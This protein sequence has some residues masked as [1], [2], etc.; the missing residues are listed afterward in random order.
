M[1]AM[2]QSQTPRQVVRNLDFAASEYGATALIAALKDALEENPDLASTPEKAGSLSAAAAQ[3]VRKFKGANLP[4]YRDIAKTII[5]YAPS[6]LKGEI[7]DAV[8]MGITHLAEHDTR[9]GKYPSLSQKNSLAHPA[10]DTNG[11]KVGVFTLTPEVQVV[12]YYDNN[13]FA[14][15]SNHESDFINIITA[16]AFLKAQEDRYNLNAEMHG[17][18]SHYAD[19]DSEN[20][21]DYRLNAEGQYKFSDDLT[22]LL[23]GVLF[24][25]A[26]EDR[27]SPDDVLGLEPT[28][29]H[30]ARAFAG[31]ERNIGALTAR[32]GS[33]FEHIFFRDTD[34]S[35]GLINNTDRDM[36]H[37][38]YGGSLAYNTGS[39]LTPYIQV[40]AD[41][42]S[43]D[44]PLDDNG[45]DRD[46]RGY[47]FLLGSDISDQSSSLS[48]GFGVGV[49]R[50][51][52]DDTAFSTIT[53]PMVEGHLR[54]K[55][56]PGTRLN[57]YIDRSID[58]TTLVGASGSV[59]TGGGA[60]IEHDLTDDLMISVRAT[61]G[62]SH[63]QEILRKDRDLEGSIGLR[64][65]INE[66]FFTAA[67]FRYQERGSNID[68]V[69]YTRNQTFFRVGLRY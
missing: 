64:Y 30:E 54:W 33:T 58:D 5:A 26:H 35:T 47:N 46:S 13:I 69:D 23:G 44:T 8:R 19:N 52:Y 20:S 11:T 29:Y 28:I 10:P 57:A 49:M 56:M 60:T 41:V 53:A 61:A 16:Y 42:R 34:T 9:V 24:M 48:A 6:N 31:V 2:A 66:N 15:G 51:N 22:R 4:V 40:M 3:S 25:R 18:F 14:T 32:L 68:A 38:T 59:Y 36:D 63:F 65:K 39:I 17:D 27:D 21:D 12:E 45:F 55:I 62:R 1:P 50:L 67:D 37:I 43:Y 7:T